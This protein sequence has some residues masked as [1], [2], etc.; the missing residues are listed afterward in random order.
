MRLSRVLSDLPVPATAIGVLGGLLLIFTGNLY[1]AVAGGVLILGGL[2]VPF[3]RLAPSD[4]TGT[5][6][7]RT[8]GA[9]SEEPPSHR[10]DESRSRWI[11]I[12]H[13]ESGRAPGS[14]R[15]DEPLPRDRPEPPGTAE[16]GDAYSVLDNAIDEQARE[17]AELARRVAALE[18]ARGGRIRPTAHVFG[19]RTLATTPNNATLP[20]ST[21]HGG[22]GDVSPQ[23]A[24]NRPER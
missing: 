23:S 15:G 20:P 10:Q 16:T 18:Q 21:Q 4:K 22:T 2:L 9:P 5:T 12:A 7:P 24:Q 8:S 14:H 17:I 11:P 19:Q 13:A 1:A 6:R 3:L